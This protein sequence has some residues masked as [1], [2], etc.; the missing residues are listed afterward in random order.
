MQKNMEELAT[1]TET[2][3]THNTNV[4]NDLNL[5]TKP[6]KRFLGSK[7]KIFLLS[8]VF[9]LVS[10][11]LFVGIVVAIFYKPVK[12]TVTDGSA[13]YSSVKEIRDSVTTQ[14]LQK[15][16]ESLDKVKKNLS[17]VKEDAKQFQW[18]AKYP[19]IGVYVSDLTHGLNAFEHALEAGDI[20]VHSVEPYADILG[21]KGQGTFA[22]GTTEDR[23]V[24]AVETLDKV[25]PQL[26]KVAAKLEQIKTEVSYIDPNRYPETIQGRQIREQITHGKELLLVVDSFFKEAMPLAKKLPILLGSKGEAKYLVLFQNDKELRPTGGFLTAYAVFRVEKGKMHLEASDDIYKLDDTITK[27]ITPPEPLKKYLNEHVFYIRNANFS[28]DFKK[29]M[30]TFMDIYKTSSDKKK[31]DGIVALDTHVLVSIMEVIGPISAYGM[32][33]TT[34]KVP[35]CDCPMIIYEL[36]KYADEPKSYARGD[37]KDII[38]VL[39]T[40]ILKKTLSSPKQLLEKMIPV[41]LKE[42]NQKHILVY[43]NDLDGQSGLESLGFAGRIRPTENGKDYLHI[44]DSNLGGAKS[45]L[46][47]KQ[48]ATLTVDPNNTSASH[49]LV[50]EYKYP[51]GPDNCSLERKGGLCLAGIYRNYLRVYIP[52]DAKLIEAIGYE[53]KNSVFEDL[54]HQVVDGFFTLTPQGVKTIQIKYNVPIVNDPYKL[55]VQKQPGTEGHKIR[56][57]ANGNSI[58][59]DLE[60][61]LE[62]E[63]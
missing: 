23:I 4:A 32:N 14:D 42:A 8:L 1:T 40:Q 28:P 45:N 37:R 30:D 21:L 13:L 15:V 41:V 2:M 55:V 36:E 44:S 25:V 43:L 27:R 7:L 62:I 19:F 48:K 57:N 12:K 11:S 6:P 10:V 29:S 54:G 52:K 47:V 18:L 53:S 5:N 63:L 31:L 59:K 60:T 49:T 35:Q 3:D 38:G 50:I 58:E 17:L 33:F 39:L 51:R 61:D 16:K 24:K 56:I 26:D 34:E 9:L 46:F 20:V 22:G